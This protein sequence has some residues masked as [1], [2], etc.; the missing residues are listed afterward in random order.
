M[1]RNIANRTIVL[2]FITGLLSFSGTEL[3]DDNSPLIG[4][5]VT[6]KQFR[7]HPKENGFSE[8]KKMYWKDTIPRNFPEISASFHGDINPNDCSKSVACILPEC[9][10]KN[11]IHWN[12]DNLTGLT[13]SVSYTPKCPNTPIMGNSLLAY[14]NA[15]DNSTSGIGIYTFTGPKPH[16]TGNAFFQPIQGNKNTKGIQGL[17]IGFPVFLSGSSMKPF[18]SECNGNNCG[19]RIRLRVWTKQSV[20]IAY[21]QSNSQTQQ[22]MAFMLYNIAD[23]Q[24]NGRIEFTPYTFC[25]GSCP[26]GD[27]AHFSKDPNQGGV[28][29]IGGRLLGNGNPTRMETNYRTTTVWES[30]GPSTQSNPFGLTWFHYEISWNNFVKT[31]RQFTDISGLNGNENSDVAQL[32]GNGWSIKENWELKHIRFAQEVYNPEWNNGEIAFVGG[33]TNWIQLDAITK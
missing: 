9:F 11:P 30:Y 31:L 3:A 33:Y 22:K 6:E 29:Y 2:F 4:Y 25:A 26:S 10:H 19:D 18:S 14:T 21:N 27:K 17:Y 13:N 24:T 8:I 23:P 5:K 20:K 1:N 12:A 32:F 15:S 16:A 7:F 28:P